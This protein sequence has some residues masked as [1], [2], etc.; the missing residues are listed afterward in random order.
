MTQW[1]KIVINKLTGDASILLIEY[2]D[3]LI[4]VFNFLI[5]LYLSCYL[6]RKY[7]LI[8]KSVQR[9]LYI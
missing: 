5:W 4:L 7:F 3:G 9:K 6:L 2:K 1:Y 8:S